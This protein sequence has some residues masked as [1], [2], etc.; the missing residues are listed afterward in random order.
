MRCE[1]GAVS[2]LFEEH[3]L[4]RVLTIDM[5][6]MGDAAGLLSRAMDMFEAEAARFLE[7]FGSDRYTSSHN[8]H[9]VHPQMTAARAGMSR[10]R[11]S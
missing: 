11:L 3:Q 7:R 6:R 9:I 4:E 2:P 5:Y 8:D 10:A 1:R